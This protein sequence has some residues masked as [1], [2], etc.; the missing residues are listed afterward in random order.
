MTPLGGVPTYAPGQR[1]TDLYGEYMPFG[2]LNV[3][4]CPAVDVGCGVLGQLSGTVAV[5]V[6]GMVVVYPPGDVWL[7]IDGPP[8]QYVSTQCDRVVAY[9]LAGREYGNFVLR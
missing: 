9:I 6:Y 2:V 4:A 3:R 1:F 7:C 8:A 5:E